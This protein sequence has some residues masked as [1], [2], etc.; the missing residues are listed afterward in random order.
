[1]NTVVRLCRRVVSA[2]RLHCSDFE[3]RAE[4]GSPRN[5]MTLAASAAR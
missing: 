1:M 2:E 5:A 3:S 4:V